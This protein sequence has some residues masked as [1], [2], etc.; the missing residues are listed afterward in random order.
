[1]ASTGF[2]SVILDVWQG[3]ELRNLGQRM[4]FRSIKESRDR[5]EWMRTNT[6]KHSMELKQMSSNYM[7]IIRME[8]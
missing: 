1:M 2:S 5:R 8:P 7:D 4:G 6:R 3:K